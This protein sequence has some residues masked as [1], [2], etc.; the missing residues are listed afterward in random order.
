MRPA[1]VILAAGASERL[2]EPKALCRIGA[3][4]VLERLLAAG[5]EECDGPPLLLV[6]AHA[7][8]IAAHAPSVVE[9]ARHGEWR[10]GRTSTLKLA[11]RLRPGRDLLIAPVDV[12]LVGRAVFRALVEAW[13]AAGSP[14]AGFLA[15]RLADRALPS[16]SDGADVPPVG[17]KARHGHPV[18]LGRALALELESVSDS[19]PL[20]RLR[21]RAAP[22]FDVEVRDEHV[23][24]DLDTPADLDR[25][26]RAADKP[27][28]V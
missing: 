1:L 15:P 10:R 21:D 3:A 7:D 20:A 8:E 26:R 13:R 22:R 25:L 19:T 11:R 9:L 24:D 12:P 14:A 23:L 4:T 18:V 28:Q 27:A 5:V 2:G 17:T 16:R 6:G